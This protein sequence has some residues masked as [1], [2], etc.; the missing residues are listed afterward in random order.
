MAI[1]NVMHQ[2]T[3]EKRRGD[4]P[5]LAVEGGEFAN[6]VGQ[7]GDWVACMKE[8]AQFV[9]ILL[10]DT[11][12]PRYE[13]IEIERIGT[14]RT[15]RNERFPAFDERELRADARKRLAREEMMR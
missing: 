7:D 9:D 1:Q 4:V 11:F 12:P 10:V 14:L 15:N 5:F 2:K 3:I 8:R 6:Q 13:T